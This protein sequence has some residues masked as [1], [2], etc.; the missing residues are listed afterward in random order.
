MSKISVVQLDTIQVPHHAFEVHV[1]EWQAVACSPARIVYDANRRIN[2]VS[3]ADLPYAT[4]K[5]SIFKIKPV[6][7]VKSMQFF[8]CRFRN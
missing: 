8:I 3:Y 4:T 2:A 1:Q 5:I 7:L 6:T